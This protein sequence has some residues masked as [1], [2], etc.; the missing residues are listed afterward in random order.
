MGAGPGPLQAT[1][2]F[3][4]G[5]A[6]EPFALRGNRVSRDLQEDEE[7]LR[8]AELEDRDGPALFAVTDRRV[9]LHYVG[10]GGEGD[11][12]LR[13]ETARARLSDVASFIDEDGD[14]M[15]RFRIGDADEATAIG[16]FEADVADAVAEAL[17]GAPGAARGADFAGDV[18]NADAAP[19]LG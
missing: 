15:L 7:L 3:R 18:E 14:A 17:G 8:L 6:D 4:V 19:S 10:R 2:A 13:R 12:D 9:I 5:M 1:I 16:P 11:S